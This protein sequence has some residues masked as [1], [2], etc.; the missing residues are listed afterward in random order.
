[1]NMDQLSHIV[2][3]SAL[4][5]HSGLGPGLFENV[6]EIV[7]FRDLVAKGLSVER[8]K[9]V[10]F[11]FEGYVFERGFIADLVVEGTLLIEVKS[12]VKI[13]I[14]E[15]KQVNTY[16]RLMELPLGLILNFGAASLRDGI[17][18]VIN[19]NPHAKTTQPL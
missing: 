17:K 5:I 7:L 16:L 10:T 9:S 8:Q 2:I 11:N 18:R 19:T 13:G 6:Y 1:M 14:L 12:I 3:G 15:I 4:R